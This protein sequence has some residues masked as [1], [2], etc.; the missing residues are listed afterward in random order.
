MS[1]WRDKV[2]NLYDSPYIYKYY[3]AV[4]IKAIVEGGAA[5]IL[6][7]IPGGAMYVIISASSIQISDISVLS[8]FAFGAALTQT[9]DTFIKKPADR[10][11]TTTPA[12]DDSSDVSRET[13]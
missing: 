7:M 6:A 5:I 2:E 13:T 9:Y 4:M 1:P 10:E 12:T 11:S 8:V 3:L